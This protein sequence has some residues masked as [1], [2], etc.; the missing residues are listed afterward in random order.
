MEFKRI[1]VLA[2]SVKYS[3]RCIAG[4]EV[5]NSRRL[6]T[7]SWVR[8]IS[9]LP[10]G[11]LEMKHMRIEGGG[12]PAVLD[13]VVVPLTRHADD[14]IHP[15]DWLI[16]MSKKWTKVK[17]HVPQKLLELEE[18][19]EH[20]WLESKQHTD[21]VS[22]A[23]L[24]KQPKLQSLYLIRPTEFHVEF[25]MR[26][27]P[28]NPL[29]TFRRRAQFTY[30]GLRYDMSLTDPIFNEAYCGKLPE[31]DGAVKV[32]LPP[33]GD[34]CLLCL[35]VTPLYQNHHWKVVATVLGLS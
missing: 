3:A 6:G 24:L 27:M 34:N 5:G 31:I 18:Q 9:N 4:I 2:N 12:T 16:E 8:P 25:S 35:S 17:T 20:L 14:P 28:G 32:V 33:Y 10:K 15:E 7:S 19:P 21:R 23:F 1:I 26:Q 11:E 13:D 30:N 29:P 22:S